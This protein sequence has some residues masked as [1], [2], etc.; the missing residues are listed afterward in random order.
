[1]N[2][3]SVDLFTIEEHVVIAEWLGVKPCSR[4][5]EFPTIYGRLEKSHGTAMIG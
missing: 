1:M 4:A 5:K 2:T 3:K